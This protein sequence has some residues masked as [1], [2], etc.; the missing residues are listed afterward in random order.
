MR[1]R[2]TDT[3]EFKVRFTHGLDDIVTEAAQSLH[4]RRATYIGLVLT[5]Y[6][7]EIYEACD[8]DIANAPMTC[9][10]LPKAAEAYYAQH[11]SEHERS[12][13]KQ[14]KATIK[15]QTRDTIMNVV[16]ATGLAV[17]QL[18]TSIV[19]RWAIKENIL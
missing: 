14:I 7:N 3:V 15:M 1:P 10:D 2:V 9:F 11:N 18:A 19:V 16:S 6:A 8:G 13:G 5:Q 4:L 17:P 12:L